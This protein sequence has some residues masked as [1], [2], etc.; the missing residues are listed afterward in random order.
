MFVPFEMIFVYLIYED[1]RSVKGDVSGQ[2]STGEKLAWIGIATLG[3]IVIPIIIIS[4]IG[5]A[6]MHSLAVFQG[7]IPF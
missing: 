3:Y 5:T 7:T 1:L 2:F 4:L 6:F